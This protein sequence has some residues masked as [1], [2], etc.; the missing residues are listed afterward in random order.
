MTALTTQIAQRQSQLSTQPDMQRDVQTTSQIGTLDFSG[1][2]VA[3]DGQA[4]ARRQMPQPELL[5]RLAYRVYAVLPAW[6]QAR[7]IT[8]AAPKVTLGVCAVIEDAH[9]RVL[10]AHHTYRRCAWGLPGGLIRHGEQPAAALARELREELGCVAHIGPVL[11]AHT[12]LAT[13]HLTLFYRVTLAG[14]PSADGVELDSLRFVA[15][16]DLP[17]LLGRDACAWLTLLKWRR[18]S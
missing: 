11:G 12:A 7:A 1:A 5:W 18:A 10:A 9:G 16:D 15:L 3:S 17:A 8:L 2:C 4:P 14:A 13:R 6:G